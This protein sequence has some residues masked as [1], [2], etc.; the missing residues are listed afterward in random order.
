VF[1]LSLP[2]VAAAAAKEALEL[3][4][5]GLETVP[6]TLLAI[7]FV[8]SAMVGY[9]TIRYFLRYLAHHSLAAFAYYRFAVAVLTL[10]W[11][12]SRRGGF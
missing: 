10:A 1:L 12:A 3:S 9:L 8:S 6:V 2:A 7:G 11:L 4:D 5:I